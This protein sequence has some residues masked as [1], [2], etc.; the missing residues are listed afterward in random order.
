MKVFTYIFYAF[1]II[2]TVL[3]PLYGKYFANN[4]WEEIKKVFNITILILPLFG[5]FIWIGVIYFMSDIITLWTGSD[6]Y[7]VGSLF[8][9]FFGLF[10]YLTGYVNSY[11]TLLY[12][13]GEIKSIIFL[14][15]FEVVINI[16]VAIIL[17]YLLGLIGIAIGISVAIAFISA[18]LFPKYIESQTNQKLLFDFSFHRK[19][20]VFVLLPNVIIAFLVTTFCG[21]FAIKFF[22]FIFLS[23]IYFG[24]SWNILTT[25][26]KLY[27]MSLIKLKKDVV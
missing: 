20:F 25:N 16:V 27:I 2:N 21:I 10:F 19:Q 1:T 4:Q 14:R 12:S 7:Y 23:V 6:T 18:R 26:D 24:I 5:G 13:I 9:L 3:A 8:I 11:I 17:T 22:I 15:W